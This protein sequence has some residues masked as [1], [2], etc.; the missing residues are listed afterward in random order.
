MRIHKI[1]IRRFAGIKDLELSLSDNFTLLY[2]RNESGKSTVLAFIRA[3]FYGL[4]RQNK[5]PEKNARLRFTP[6][7]SSDLMQGSILFS[8]QD[9]EFNLER[10]FGKTKADDRVRLWNHSSYQDVLLKNPDAPGEE[11]FSLTEREFLVSSLVA[12]P[13]TRFNQQNLDEKIVHIS[14]SG[15]E[16]FSIEDLIYALE[17]E[18]KELT[19]GPKGGALGEA[20][21]IEEEWEKRLSRALERDR[22]K[23]EIESRVNI[24]ENR[25]EEV[26]KKL[27]Y[28]DLL[29]EK[30][31]WHGV[32]TRWQSYI[33]KRDSFFQS[34]E[35]E[36]VYSNKVKQVPVVELNALSEKSAEIK[37]MKHLLEKQE[38]SLQA[39]LEKER[40]LSL[41]LHKK[42]QLLV[43]ISSEQKEFLARPA[44][45]IHE[46]SG[47]KG[48][49]YLPLFPLG[50]S[51]LATLVLLFLMFT[52]KISKHVLLYFLAFLLPIGGFLFY[53]NLSS[54]AEEE[55]KKR[56][57]RRMKM[58]QQLSQLDEDKK[59]CLWYID[60]LQTNISELVEDT[61]RQK[62]AFHSLEKEYIQA[63]KSLARQLKP[64][65]QTLPDNTE[66]SDLVDELCDFSLEAKKRDFWIKKYLSPQENEEISNLETESVKAKERLADLAEKI[67]SFP[68][69]YAKI[70]EKELL[71]KR[72]I[73][74]HKELAIEHVELKNSHQNSDDTACL[75]KEWRVSKNTCQALEEEILSNKLAQ[76]ILAL[77]SESYKV[78]SRPELH[79]RAN[80]WLAI[81]SAGKYEKMQIS[82][83]WTIR[84]AN[85]EEDVYHHDSFYSSGTRDLIFLSLRLAIGDMLNRNDQGSIPLLLD[86]SFVL[87]DAERVKIAIDALISYS[88][89]SG[90]QILLCS[91]DEA[92]KEYAQTLPVQVLELSPLVL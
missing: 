58:R 63:Q 59:K 90:R 39:N 73:D 85:H 42:R 15:D 71:R 79:T 41:D 92:I 68:E 48:S 40:Q 2:G 78:K 27:S 91:S 36:P 5:N 87:L 22:T 8:L 13:R 81:L 83:D 74:L 52:E 67:K 32:L 44:D 43:K 62:S 64:W 82:T 66:P 34:H 37:Q 75:E 47:K 3:M 28:I 86:D 65:Y 10:T 50:L 55:R 20:Q 9:E 7:N 77:S 56:F 29:E 26:E 6:W 14:D 23:S 84:L 61:R 21:K 16:H 12:S 53:K 45:A 51:L 17:R 31:Y 25:L 19:A 60:M 76:A 18:E 24:L 49:A 70:R 57:S 11:L 35:E 89:E 88:K 30:D 1:T 69:E 80:N 4:G 54:K 38:A 72:Q 33:K 46:Q